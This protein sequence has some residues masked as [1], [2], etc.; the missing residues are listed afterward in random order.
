MRPIV[1]FI[2]SPLYLLSKQLALIIQQ[3]NSNSQYRLRD[4]DHFV[5]D[6]R[7]F[8]K[9]RSECL[10]PIS[11]DIINLYTT[12]PMDEAVELCVN[13][14][15]AEPSILDELCILPESFEKLLKL[16]IDCCY[17]EYNGIY[18]EQQEGGPMGSS[19]TVELAERRVQHLEEEA[20]NTSPVPVE[21]WRRFVDDN[22]GN[23]KNKEDS[24][25]FFNHI[26]SINPKL[27]FTIEHPENNKLPFLD[28]ITHLPSMT[29]SVHRKPT[30]TSRYL[31]YLSC[32]PQSTKDGIVKCLTDRA[33]TVCDP[34]F[35]AEEL[36]TITNAFTT[37][38]CRLP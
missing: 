33:F 37:N 26:N 10:Y 23:F 14:F 38:G 31:H 15:L 8:R 30:S 21:F 6:F 27:Q 34:E 28:T 5:T 9:N 12:C 7:E 11:L 2:D 19:L 25:A 24:I 16:C 18:Y 20:I 17:F 32:H 3:L 29:L 4:T 36:R 35:L 13:M 22:Y 1:A